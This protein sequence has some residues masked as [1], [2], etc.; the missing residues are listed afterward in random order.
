[1]LILAEAGL[2]RLGFES[3]ISSLLVRRHILRLVRALGIE[4]RSDDDEVVTLLKSITDA[5]HIRRGD[6]RAL[7]AV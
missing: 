2:T 6:R 5:A 7:S 3:R 1:M 4:C